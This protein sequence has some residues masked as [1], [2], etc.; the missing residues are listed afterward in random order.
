MKFYATA[1]LRKEEGPDKLVDWNISECCASSVKS[2]FVSF[3]NPAIL[4]DKGDFDKLLMNI[5]E[6]DEPC[7]HHTFFAMETLVM[8]SY[9]FQQDQ[10]SCAEIYSLKT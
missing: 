7:L 4:I 3:G 9:S 6:P 1:W 5:M 8:I 2:N 10:L